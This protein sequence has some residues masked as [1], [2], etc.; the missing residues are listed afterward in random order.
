MSLC[1]LRCPACDMPVH[2]YASM[3]D[4][5]HLQPTEKDIF[6]FGSNEAGIHGAGSALHA[7]K[8]YAALQSV[9]VG[10]MGHAYAIPTK[11]RTIKTL[12][13]DKIAAYVRDF[14][15]YA[16]EHTDLTFHVVKIGCGLA[17]YTVQDIAPMF[18]GY[19]SNVK[20]PVDFMRELI[21]MWV[22]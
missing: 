16:R 19:P 2:Q 11:D 13:L 10:R 3:C 17:G 1:W 9:G 6:V 7:R 18:R 20:L 14:L 8:Y 15:S 21:P 4:R 5:G 12:P 22:D